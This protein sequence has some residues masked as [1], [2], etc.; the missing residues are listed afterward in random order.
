MSIAGSNFQNGATVRIGGV[1][2]TGVA[3][4]SGAQVDASTPALEPGK[5]HN[6]TVTNPSTLSATLSAG[7]LADFTPEVER[8][9]ARWR[10]AGVRVARSTELAGGSLV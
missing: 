9:M 3:V 5:L 6:V 4:M 10:E 7:F 1:A 2:A 8:A